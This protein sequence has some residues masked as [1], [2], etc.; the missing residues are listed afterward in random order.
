M[1]LQGMSVWVPTNGIRQRD[2]HYR[3]ES[4]RVFG[5]ATSVPLLD[6]VNAYGD[7]APALVC[8]GP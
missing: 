5:T 3:L 1:K 4:R 6:P 8:T 7:V 2:A